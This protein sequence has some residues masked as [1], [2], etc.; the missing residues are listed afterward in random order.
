V[1]PI[2][3]QLLFIAGAFATVWV[4]RSLDFRMPDWMALI[5]P[6]AI[7]SLAMFWAIERSWDFTFGVLAWSSV[8]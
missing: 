3:G 6:Y 4:F 8:P 1:I 5:P 2:S 7:G